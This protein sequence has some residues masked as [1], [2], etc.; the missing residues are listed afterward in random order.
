[1]HGLNYKYRIG[2]SFRILWA[3][4]V[5]NLVIL[6]LIELERGRGDAVLRL[7][8]IGERPA[9]C[10]STNNLTLITCQLL[11]TNHLLRITDFRR[12]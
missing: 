5:R 10:M 12:T 2:C 1:M 6:Q 4:F 8:P 9:P 3:A 11:P 7:A